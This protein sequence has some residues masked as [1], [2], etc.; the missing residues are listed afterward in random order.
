MYSDPKGSDTVY[1][2][3]TEYTHPGWLEYGTKSRSEIFDRYNG[4]MVSFAKMVVGEKKN[5]VD[6]D[7]ELELYETILKCCGDSV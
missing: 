6:L 2:D 3:K 1:T 4:M 5:D 7:Y